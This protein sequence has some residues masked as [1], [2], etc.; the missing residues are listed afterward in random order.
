[1]IRALVVPPAARPS[2]AALLSG[3]GCELEDADDQGLAGAET[4]LDAGSRS[5]SPLL[6]VP[7]SG[8]N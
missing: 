1:M 6:L 2:V 4:A 5:P 8:G 3:L 7:R